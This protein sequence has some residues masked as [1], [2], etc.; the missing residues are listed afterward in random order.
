MATKPLVGILMGSDSDLSVMEE[1]AK[2]LREF[3]IPYEITV[4]SAHRTP[5]RTSDYAKGAERRGIR[6]IIAGAGAAAHLAG[7]IAAETTL[8]VIGVPIDSSPLNGLDALLSTVQMPGGV[9]VAS[10]AIGKAGAKNAGIFAA[11]ILSVADERLRDALKRHRKEM[12]KQVEEKA[13][14][15]KA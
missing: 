13:R 12:A 7:F 8:P 2:M 4:S 9:P 15:L 10:M 3:N 11:E 14:K 5:K 1:A 6:V